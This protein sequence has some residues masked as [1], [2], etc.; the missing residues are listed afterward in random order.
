MPDLQF[1]CKLFD[2]ID[3]ADV[4]QPGHEPRRDVAF[5]D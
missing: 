3:E 1:F 2:A 4:F 5:S